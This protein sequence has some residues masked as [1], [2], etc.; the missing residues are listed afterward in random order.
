[1]LQPHQFDCRAPVY[2]RLGVHSIINCGGVRTVYGNSIVSDAVLGAMASA[3]GRYILIEELAEAIGARIAQCTGAE[4]GIVTAGSAAALALASAA[5]MAG[6]DPERMLRLPRTEGMRNVALVPGGHRFA[7]DHAIRS[8][9]C[10]IVEIETR[11]EAEHALK[12]E[13]VALISVLAGRE[14]G[15]SLGLEELAS[16]V[17]PFRV[18]ILVDAAS[19]FLETPNPWIARG[20][21]LVV[22]S[23]S[24]YM[25]G[26]PAT[27][28]LIGTE[29]L[30]R[31]AWLN[32]APHQA[33]G[34]TMKVGKEQ[35]VGALV[36][37]ETWLERDAAAERQ[38]WL[39]RLSVIAGSVGHLSGVA[40]ETL[41]GPGRV[42]TLRVSW[43]SE[44]A[45]L[46]TD[47]LRADLLAGQPRV[48]IDDIGATANSVMIDP[49]G[50]SDRE[51]VIVGDALAN[52]LGAQ[53][54]ASPPN[55][56]PTAIG[57]EWTVSIEFS[58]AAR[59]HCFRLEQDGRKLRGTHVLSFAT[60]TIEGEVDGPDVL[61]QSFHRLEGS[62][63]RF[64]FSGKVGADGTMNGLV[65]MGHAAEHTQ[66]PVAFGQF[67][68][69]RWSATKA[70]PALG[71][72]PH[73]SYCSMSKEP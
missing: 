34:R 28:L 29:R 14:L 16:I 31:A 56:D 70:E 64:R 73:G 18:P 51:A 11:E 40:C 60:T 35:M 55:A 57:G 61:L 3:A 12:Q 37:L 32:G 33:F 13:N 58:N 26:P 50:L 65:T 59:A 44:G 41:T 43:A 71:Q 36:A 23:V 20:A 30:V 53:R 8:A 45:P 27:G 17:A 66:G 39:A 68:A 47:V 2:D 72:S 67:G 19:E 48:L 4:W 62:I 21:D 69:A 24:K 5:C 22:Y 10:R 49:F 6:N 38:A 9:G 54:V 15:P 46:S 42:P 7:Y 52:Q 1:M 63:V 25:R